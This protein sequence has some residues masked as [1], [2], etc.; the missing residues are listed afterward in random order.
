MPNRRLPRCRRGM[1]QPPD[2]WRATQNARSSAIRTA[3]LSTAEITAVREYWQSAS[4]AITTPPSPHVDQRV[5]NGG[6]QHIDSTLRF[7]R[8]NQTESA[9]PPGRN[10]TAPLHRARKL[11]ATSPRRPRLSVM[12]DHRLPRGETVCDE[13]RC[14]LVFLRKRLSADGNIMMMKLS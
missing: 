12:I 9:I 5:L 1:P 6:K 7:T 13:C 8:G 4:P 2:A 11:D 14:L 10:I 3:A